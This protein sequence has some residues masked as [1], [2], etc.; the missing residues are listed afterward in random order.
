MEIKELI[1]DIRGIYT[2]SLKE[3]D[4]RGYDIKK[5][6][7]E[8]DEIESTILELEKYKA[9]W[10]EIES[11]DSACEWD[12]LDLKKIK[13]KYFSKPVKKTITIE[14][15]SRSE[16]LIDRTIRALKDDKS[17]GIESWYGGQVKVNVKEVKV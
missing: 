12:C 9:M 6:A 17:S 15:E 2:C 16:D 4:K 3:A 8:F 11:V 13:E 5:Y 10:E 1:R 14:F 7:Q